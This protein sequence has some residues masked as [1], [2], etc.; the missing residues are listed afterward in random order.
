MSCAALGFAVWLSAC[1]GEDICLN[2]NAVPTPTPGPQN[3][4]GL[5]G[6]IQRTESWFGPLSDVMVL[7]CV[8]SS[9][10]FA[11]CPTVYQTEVTVE[12]QFRRTRIDPGSLR[13]AFWVD[14]NE[15]GMIDPN[16]PFAELLDPESELVNVEEDETVTVSEAVVNFGARTAVAGIG[17][18][19]TPTPAPTSVPTPSPAP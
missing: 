8:D 19:P 4:V 2:C 12:G 13:V 14:Q 18:D 16:D 15:D 6:N 9:S 3:T 5:N 7:V 17:V 1:G 11:N 10:D